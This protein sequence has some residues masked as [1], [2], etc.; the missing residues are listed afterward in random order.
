MVVEKIYLVT[1]QCG[2]VEVVG[3]GALVVDSLGCSQQ[4][5]EGRDIAT[6]REAQHRNVG[7]AQ[8]G[9]I[10]KLL[11]TAEIHIDICHHTTQYIGVDY[12][13]GVQTRCRSIHHHT[14]TV[15]KARRHRDV[16]RDEID[17][18]DRTLKIVTRAEVYLA[19]NTE[20]EAFISGRK[21]KLRIVHLLESIAACGLELLD[22]PVSLLTIIAALFGC[23]DV[24]IWL[25]A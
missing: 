23:N 24:N 19:T 12:R 10:R 7:R 16:V 20:H 2:I 1:Q 15:S 8:M 5:T 11:A 25:T 18:I 17:I 3:V 21:D 22:N 14:L 6:S 13:L 4:V 9:Y